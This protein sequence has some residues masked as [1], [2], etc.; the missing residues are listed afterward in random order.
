MAIITSDTYLDG[1][2]ARTAGEVWTC[3][4]GILTIRTDTRWHANSPASMTGTLGSVTISA[5]LGGGYYIDAT[6][7]R[8]LAITGGSGTATIGDTIS[9]GGVSGYFLGYW[10]SLT[11][12][13]SATI[14][15]TGFIKLREV[16]GG[17][18]SAG[19]LTFSGSGAATAA[20][21]DIT[22]WIEVV[23]DQATAITVPRLGKFQTRG[24]W[25]YLDN[26]TG[27]ANQ[28]IQIPTDG[29]ATAYVPAVWIET[30]SGSNVYE[31][32]PAIYAAAMITTNLGTD[33]RS[34]FVCMETNGNIRI[35]HNGTTSVGYVPSSGCKVRIPNILGRQCATGTRAT[36]AIPNAIVGTRPDFTTTSAGAIDMEYFMNDWYMYFL[37]PYQVRAYHMA[38]FERFLLSEVATALDIDDCGVGHS[39]SYDVRAFNATSCFAGGTVQNSKF[40]R[41]SSGSSDHSF[42]LLYS[43]GITVSNVYSGIITFARSTGMSFQS[44]QCSDITYSNCYSYNQAIQFTTSF[45]C[46]VNDCDHCDRYVGTTNTTGIYAVYILAS[47][48]NILV[49]GVTFGYQGTIANVHPYLGIFNVGQSSNIKLR[50]VG[51]RTTALSGGSANSP[52]Y[53]YVSAGNNNTVKLQR[54]YMTPT[55]TGVI[56]TLNSDKNMTYEHVYGDMGDTMVLASLN[57]VAKNCGGTTSVTG[58][59]SVYGTHFWDAFTSD[60]VGRVTLPMNEQTTETTSLV[61]IVAGTPKFTSAGQLTMQSVNDEIIIEQSYFVKGCTALTNTAPIVSGTNVTYVSGPD[62]GN[63]DIYYQ[64]DTGS[65]YGGTW[66]DLTAANLSGE[67]IS[68]STGFKLKYRIVCD[69]ASTTNAITYIRITTNSTLASQTDNLYP[70]ETVTVSVTAKDAITFVAIENARVFLEADTGGALPAEESVTTITRSGSTASVAHTAHGMS[71][72]QKVVIR[73]AV[74]YEYNGAFVIS[75]VT[76]NA[77]DYTL[78]GTPTTPATGTI[79]ATAL[80]MTGVTNASGVYSESLEISGDQPVFGK[81][82]RAS[83]GT[84]YQ[85]GTIVGTITSTG[86]DNTT[87]LIPDE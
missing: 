8:W 44:T 5:T 83:T 35:G 74:E 66:K 43:S 57:S 7:V 28:Q 63:H 72:G 11:S 3:N 46:T 84:K 40:Q 33:A 21:A 49:D 10:A 68:A 9:Q 24:D 52:A 78:T 13:P 64:I 56:S 15:A 67:T 39:A 37:Q 16:T 14:G 30:S 81:I 60:T 80:I 61:T 41:V 76:T 48:D 20:G 34:K 54:I 70:L 25:F 18:F 53:I 73:G 55:R 75:N 50:N 86:L 23:Q 38:T 32:Y 42:E 31:I 82:R 36:N 65:G 79:T 22:G 69:T 29:S 51:T 12:A 87:L 71:A 6:N 77:Y 1:G 59:A 58:Q 26:T 2:T 62:W 27:A 45:D 85:T 4:G 19:A 17:A 47:S